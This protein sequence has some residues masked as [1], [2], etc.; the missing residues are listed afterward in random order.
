VKR[1]YSLLVLAGLGL[2]LGIPVLVGGRELLPVL[3][4][5]QPEHLVMMLGMILL[6]WNFN[7]G[8]IRLLIGGFGYRL[9]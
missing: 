2:G 1:R 9:K 4:R 6:A 8:R 5:L 7:A 3:A